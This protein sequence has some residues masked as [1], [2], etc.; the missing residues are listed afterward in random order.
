MNWFI[1]N[2]IFAS[3]ISDL[4]GFV[5]YDVCPAHF[6]QWIHNEGFGLHSPPHGLC[7]PHGLAGIHLQHS[8]L[9]RGAVH[10]CLLPIPQIQV[11]K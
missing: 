6:L 1:G 9:S 11:N 10:R 5:D 2:S 4:C 3:Y 8:G 7:H